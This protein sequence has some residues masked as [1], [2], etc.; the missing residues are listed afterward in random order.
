MTEYF[1]EGNNAYGDR[2]AVL[3][4]QPQAGPAFASVEGAVSGETRRFGTRAAS[5]AGAGRQSVSWTSALRSVKV[6]HAF[7]GIN[8]TPN[9][10]LFF[11]FAG[12]T[13]W[14]GVVYWVRHNE[15]LANQVLGT[16]AAYSAT[17]HAD[18]HIVAGVRHAMPLKTSPTTGMIYVPNTPPLPEGP[19]HQ[20]GIP[21]SAVAIHPSAPA[22]VSPLAQPLHHRRAYHVPVSSP[23]GVRLKTVVN[24]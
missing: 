22:A 18:R 7:Q 24:R 15:P 21:A 9:M 17:G 1:Q 11:M 8:I 5:A 12:F 2:V 14:L 4:G 23:D 6:K 3:P 20:F 16:G 19:A 13:A 10:L